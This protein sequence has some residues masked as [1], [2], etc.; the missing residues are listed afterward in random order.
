HARAWPA[1][2]GE[3]WYRRPTHPTLASSMPPIAASLE[4]AALEVLAAQ[5]ILQHV[6]RCRI[7][8]IA[9]PRRTRDSHAGACRQRA[10][11]AERQRPQ[12]REHANNRPMSAE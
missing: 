3:K 7:V 5:E 4:L 11:T 1:H 10:Q 2:D 9:A 8:V 12:D 6:D